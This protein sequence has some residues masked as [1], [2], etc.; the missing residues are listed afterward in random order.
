MRDLNT[1]A[2]FSLRDSLVALLATEASRQKAIAV[3]L[4][5]AL[6]DLAIQMPE[7]KTAVQ[8]MVNKFGSSPETAACLLEFLTILPEEIEGN[9]RLPLTVCPN[10]KLAFCGQMKIN[11]NPFRIRNTGNRVRP[12]WSRMQRK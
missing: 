3:Q 11:A 6:A 7:W 8:D 1:E 2:R 9:S 4:C 12:C 10:T 5:L